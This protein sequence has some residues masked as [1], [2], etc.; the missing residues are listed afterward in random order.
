MNNSDFLV[1]GGGVAGLSAA[2]ALAAHGRVALVEAEDALGYHSSGRSV[3]FSH[4]GIG[5]RIVRGLTDHSRALFLEN[6][7]LARPSPALFFATEAML[8]VLDELYREMARFT[9]ALSWAD[10]RAMTSLFPPLHTGPEA[11]VRGIIDPGGLK[12]DADALLQ[13]Y[14]RA[15]RAAGGSLETGRRVAAIVR[16]GGLWTATGECG[17]QWSAPILIDAAGAWADRIAILAGVRLLGLQPKRRTVIVLDAPGGVDPR[18]WPFAKT[19]TDEFYMLPEGGALLASPVDEIASD[20]CDCRPDEYDIALAADRVERY[21]TL[22]VRRIAHSW[23]GL[24]SFV[25]DR[26]PTAGFAPD[27]PG[28]FW[29]AGQGGYGLQTAPAMAEIVA[30]L[31][32]GTRW[33]ASLTARGVEPEHILPGRLFA[34]EG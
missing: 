23:A 19:A 8:G 24:R 13:H 17:G 29:L 15:L 10:E 5:N 16:R 34:N 32:T 21:T 33:P 26:V 9:D 27:A 3:A 25:A 12:L 22:P 2:A 11:A 31:V 14:A 6:P 30:A 18:G 4:F 1:I 28:F 7:A 20:P